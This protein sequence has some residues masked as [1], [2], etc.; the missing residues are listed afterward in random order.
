M[1]VD[2]ENE[3]GGDDNSDYNVNPLADAPKK[4]GRSQARGLRG[5]PLSTV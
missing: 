3:I 4:S 1:D 5:T 2:G